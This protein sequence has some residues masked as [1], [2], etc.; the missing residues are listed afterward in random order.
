MAKKRKFKKKAII[1]L[2]VL[3]I[4]I[5]LG[6]F[7]IIYFVNK[8][9]IK[10]EVNDL[11]LEI[12]SEVSVSSLVKSIENG[13]LVNGED[14]IDTSKLGKQTITL[15]IENK[16]KNKEFD[17][18]VNVVDTTKPV[19]E[20]DKSITTFLG[21]NIDLL[22][23]AIVS[24]N[25][26]EEL[27]A[28]IEGDYNIKKVGKYDL[29]YKAT[30]S[31]GNTTEQVVTLNVSND[32]NNYSFTTSK[33]YKGEVKKGV[34]YIDGVL[35]ANKTYALPSTYGS[36]LTKTLNTAFNK[37]KKDATNEGLDIYISSGFRSYSTQE[38]TYDYWVSL[39]GKEL[40]DTYSA[41]PGHSEHQTGLAI[42]L[43]SIDDSFASTK[44]GKWVNEN[45]YKYGFIIRYP[46]GKDDITGY[47]YESWHLR[48]VGVELAT[49]LYNNGKWI[50]MEEYYGITSEYQNN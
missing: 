26:K 12:Y 7:G 46:K 15:K 39:D 50:T 29:K 6:I 21:T 35:I 41:R 27:K 10:Y 23:F 3:L 5:V 20:V 37:M 16:K 25:S 34:T 49:K 40:A 13:T 18:E 17:I 2:V 43:N 8:N 48:Y 31:S 11:N 42:D 38:Y 47:K 44:E 36:G 33:G 28:T 30:D 32:S 19:I 45:C 9:K 24:D 22:T 4:L 14:I 1:I